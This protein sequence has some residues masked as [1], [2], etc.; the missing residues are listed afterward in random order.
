MDALEQC[1]ILSQ[2]TRVPFKNQIQDSWNLPMVFFF[3][4][5]S[6]RWTWPTSSLKK[7]PLTTWNTPPAKWLKNSSGPHLAPGASGD[8]E[9][10]LGAR[11][12]VSRFWKCF[13]K[14][15]NSNLAP[16]ESWPQ[17]VELAEDAEKSRK[18]VNLKVTGLDLYMDI[19]NKPCPKQWK[20]VGIFSANKVISVLNHLDEYAEKL[21]KTTWK[22]MF[23]HFKGRGKSDPFSLFIRL[24]CQRHHV[25]LAD[26]FL[27]D[28]W[29]FDTLGDSWWFLEAC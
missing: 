7:V 28:C 1:L 15:W 4:A 29:W 12:A 2:Q 6:K 17:T 21:V 23:I 3:F 14:C 24:A 27:G 11:S 5:I 9:A 10:S 22:H 19:C 16:G 8:S 26:V 18:K 25:L 20:K 13:K